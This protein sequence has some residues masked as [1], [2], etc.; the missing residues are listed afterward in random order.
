MILRVVKVIAA[1]SVIV[2]LCGGCDKSVQSETDSPTMT[3]EPTLEAAVG[4]EYICD[5]T[6]TGSPAPTFA[7]AQAPAG[8]TIDSAS[9]LISWVP[10]SE[11]PFDSRI[12]VVASNRGGTDTLEFMVQVAGLQIAGWETSCLAAEDIDPAI[13]RA[14]ASDIDDGTYIQINSLLIVRNG[15]LVFEDYFNG[16]VRNRSD[17]IYSAEKS[18]TSCLMGIAIDQGL[19]ADEN[20]L[21]YPFFEEYDSYENWSGW[22][23]E[24]TL[25]HLLTMTA[26]FELEGEDY[27]LWRYD[28]GPRDWIKFYLDLPIVS[29]PGTE[30]DYRSLNDRLAGHVI[31]R[32]AEMPLPEF[33]VEHLFGPLDMKYYDW[34]AWDPV[35][36]SMI[37]SQLEL[38][39]IDMAKFGQMY[40]DDGL[41]LGNRIVSE[42][43][44][45]RST[46][47]YMGNYGY[48]WWVYQWTTPVGGIGVYYAFGN[49]GNGIWIFE[50][51]Q[52]IVVMTGDYFVQPDYWQ[53]QQEILKERIIPAAMQ[54]PQ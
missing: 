46:V 48:N 4:Q 39:P 49:G 21:L 3:S 28:V 42:E 25:K 33:A 23:D 37:S 7:L 14:V 45:A 34:S 15:K 17:N 32:Q 36:S 9:G 26:G 53:N 52:M 12:S 13:I 2:V 40:L 20:E 51:L 30:I 6:A 16:A 29:E 41:W 24:I 22:K 11:S 8:M 35:N 38:R 44:V 54:G 18:V 47:P 43:W 10:T 31:E 27:S 5:V 19:I 1:L 50:S